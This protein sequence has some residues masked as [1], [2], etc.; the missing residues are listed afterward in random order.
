MLRID[1]FDRNLNSLK[2]SRVQDRYLGMREPCKLTVQIFKIWY[3]GKKTDGNF[4]S[5]N[6]ERKNSVKSKRN[7]RE[8]C[9]I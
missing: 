6:I 2:I 9:I 8:N 3:S 7:E 4:C 1:T 5:L